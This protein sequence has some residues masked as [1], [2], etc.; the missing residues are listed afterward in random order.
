MILVNGGLEKVC[1]LYF[2]GISKINN[3]NSTNLKN[4]KDCFISYNFTVVQRLYE[5]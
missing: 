4:E 3:E 2:S 5:A 1:R